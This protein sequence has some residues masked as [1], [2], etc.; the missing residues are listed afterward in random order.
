M[1]R[2]WTPNQIKA[3]E[4]RNMQI[5]VS[6]AAGSGKT[7]VLTERVKRIL[8]DTENPCSVSEILVVTFTRAAAAEMR[9]RI[10][11]AISEEI[12]SNKGNADYLRRQMTLLPTADICTIDSFCAKIVR[13]NFHLANV[14]ADFRILDEKDEKE[15]MKYAV[16]QVVDELYEEGDDAFIALTQMFLDERGDVRLEDV[17]E[18]LYKYSRSYPSPFGWLNEIAEK[19]SPHNSLDD[20]GWT[21]V[22]CQ[23]LSM[24]SDYFASRMDRCAELLEDS[25]N[26]DANYIR[27]F[28]GTAENLK[29]L[30]E[31]SDNR[32]W[33][34]LV[35]F[36]RDGI[37]VK[38][39]SRNKN[40]D[41]DLQS[42][43][44]RV[45]KE[46]ETTLAGIEK[47][48]LPTV[49]ENTA[50]CEILYPIVNK[51]CSAVKRLSRVLDEAKF[52]KNAYG[53]DDILHK[54]IDLLVDFSDN[55]KKK[56]PLAEEL[57]L[58]YKEILIDEYQ[59]T[60][61]AQNIIFEIISRNK[62]N[63]YTVGDVKQSIYGFRLAS[64]DLFMN[65]KNT[66]AEYD[67]QEKPSQITLEN[68]FRSREGITKAV[69]SIFSGI[70]SREIG[71][72]E[73]GEKEFLN[74]SAKFPE[75]HTPDTELICVN[76]DKKD[77]NAPTEA[78]KV[79]EYIKSVVDSGVTVSDS[80]GQRKVCWG[81]FCILL[82]SAKGKAS[83]Y[84]EELKKLSIPVTVSVENG[85]SESKEIMFLTSLI[86]VINNPLM[87]IPLIA[88]LSSAVFGFTPDELSEIRMSD[89]K[90]DFYVCLV[91]YAQTNNK[92]KIFLDKLK[93]YRNISVALPI[94][95]FV[96]F[97]ISDLAVS[98]IYY[99]AGEGVQRN[100]NIRGFVKLSKDFT[101][102][103]RKGL[104][105]FVR[106]IDLAA[107]KGGLKSVDNNFVDGNSVKI[108]SI[109][110]SKGL[111]FP[112]VLIADCSKDFNRQ[113][114]YKQ[115]TFS[116]KTGLGMR[117]RND[118]MFSRYHTLS[119][120]ATE[121]SVLFSMLSEELRVLY[122][123][124]TRAKEHLTFFFNV[125]EE[126]L[127]NRVKLNHILSCENGEKLH[128]FAVYRAGSMAEWILS[129]LSN[130]RDGEV[131]RKICGIPQESFKEEAD[132]SFDCTYIESDD[133]TFS[134]ETEP[135]GKVSANE[136]LL[137]RIKN[138]I[139]Y[140]YPFDYS[141]IL[142]KRTASS[143]ESPKKK[144]EYFGTAK[145]SFL[146]ESFSGADR[147]TAV[148]KFLE[149]CDFKL[150]FE[151]V[152]KEKSRLL[153]KGLLADK[154]LAVL[155]SGSV[156]CFFNS[157]IGIRLLAS[158]EVLKEY[159]FSILKNAEELYGDLPESANKEQIVVQGKL[160]CA[161]KEDDGYVLI[162][163]KTD[164]VSDESHYI[165][166]YKNQL[167]IYGSALSQCTGCSVK[168]MYIYSFKIKKFIKI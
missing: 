112:Y 139:E 51:L 53:F 41:K 164:N 85:A 166:T 94:D 160:D 79:A 47:R 15:L 80:K 76:A 64:P 149:L 49:R 56:T 61:N 159:E 113:D 105:D 24:F 148:H 90:S 134:I 14:G 9:D 57:T 95:E 6:A 21:E 102:S 127:K 167:E 32:S 38:P 34:A 12:E 33:D 18:T 153:E 93:L 40:V 156:K 119:S 48:T 100:S 126:S 68:N 152:E 155:D 165:S 136:E 8:C 16:K 75:H 77:E 135:Q 50:D 46:F 129:S 106:Y 141:G 124:M 130:H 109:H 17:I 45:F 28:S 133:A 144:R 104:N 58:K 20:T 66:L 87:D 145:P 89:R 63:I 55:E 116:R 96:E 70:M 1:S 108:M 146:N 123:A 37:T 99:A 82:R 42:I 65:L 4:A 78:K 111:E 125:S 158:E 19:F 92:A 35:S 10:Y 138:N 7:S 29:L 122:V 157:D 73:Y 120:A 31:L 103:G 97:V 52:E 44:D 72:M 39:A 161:F 101:E 60:N 132:F 11:K 30:K 23:Y 25:G 115:L 86:K 110:K 43:T 88:T 71:E 98:D 59:D 5:L 81:D 69:N 140:V 84:A 62:T 13:E 3:I 54:A 117:I 114:A 22:L 121:K 162:D 118:E 107:E 154:E 83:K 91:K 27:R 142:A 151:D 143:T 36:L 2:E 74:Y 147:G 128:P 168:E 150:A 67:G 131:I 26:F 163:Y 137:E